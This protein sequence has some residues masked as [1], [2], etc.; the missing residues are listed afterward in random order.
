MLK[1]EVASEMSDNNLLPLCCR[2][3]PRDYAEKLMED[4]TCT[5]AGEAM[6]RMNATCKRMKTVRIAKLQ[7]QKG[8]PGKMGTESDASLTQSNP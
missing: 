4:P 2:I 3:L 7:Q 5:T 6:N 1:D 8:E